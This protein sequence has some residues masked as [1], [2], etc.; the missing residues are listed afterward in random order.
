MASCLPTDASHGQGRL[1]LTQTS[2]R[3]H[4]QVA[5]WKLPGNAHLQTP[6]REVSDGYQETRHWLVSSLLSH[7]SG[8]LLEQ[9]GIMA[10]FCALVQIITPTS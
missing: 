3:L 5:A 1:I 8:M 7:L 4:I 10:H 2:V 6:E 9:K